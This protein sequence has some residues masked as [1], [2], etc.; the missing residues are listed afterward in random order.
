MAVS[1]ELLVKIS[2]DTKDATAGIAE[3]NQSLKGMSISLKEAAAGGD[4]SLLSL[5]DS[6][7]K[8]RAANEKIV[9]SL[10]RRGKTQVDIARENKTATDQNIASIS[11]MLSQ[12]GK[13]TDAL[14]A[15]LSKTK[16]LAAAQQAATIQDAQ[17]DALDKLVKQNEAVNH[18]LEVQKADAL[19]LAAINAAKANKELDALRESLK[20]QGL[21]NVQI[22]KQ[23]TLARQNIDAQKGIDIVAAE[24]KKAAEAAKT[25]NAALNEQSKA[26]VGAGFSFIALNQALELAQKLW[27]G[28]SGPVEKAVEAFAAGEKADM[29]LSNS[30]KAMGQSSQGAFDDLKNLSKEMQRNSSISDETV[31]SMASVAKSMGLSNEQT[32]KVIKSSADMAAVMGTDVNTAFN[33]LIGQY[34]GVTGRGAKYVT[35]LKDLN[36]A[37]LKAGA[38]IELVAKQFAGFAEAEGKTLGG[39]ITQ[40]KNAF[41][42]LLETIGETISGFFDLPGSIQAAKEVILDTTKS[43]KVFA[44]RLT[45][46]KDGLSG[47]SFSEIIAGVSGIGTA[48]AVALVAL[49]VP[50]IVAALT[51]IGTALTTI[52]GPAVL[53]AGQFVLITGAIL[54]VVIAIETVVKN[55]ERL[56]QL[57]ETI[58]VAFE[59][60]F[61]RLIRGFAGVG[62]AGLSAIEMILEP[63][64][65]FSD[66]A[67]SA[68]GSVRSGMLSLGNVAED[69]GKSVDELD[70]KLVEASKGLEMGPTLGLIVQ[71]VN[72][73]KGAMGDVNV[74]TEA[75]KKGFD[76]ISKINAEIAKPTK[77]QLQ[78]LQQIRS[79]N[80]GLATEVDGMGA[81]EIERLKMQFSIMDAQ[82]AV[83]KNQLEVEGK[84]AG[85]GGQKIIAALNKQFDLQKELTQKRIVDIEFKQ[86]GGFGEAVGRGAVDFA[87]MFNVG[88][89]YLSGVFDMALP[90]ISAA[91]RDGFAV[92]AAKAAGVL[93]SVFSGFADVVMKMFDPKFIQGMADALSG[94]VEKFP[95]LLEKAF[96]ALSD[97]FGKI[98]DKLPEV[99]NKLFDALG[100]IFDKLIAQMP[101]L[102]DA[103]AAALVTF[104]ERL[105]E[106][107]AKLFDALPGIIDKLLEKLP[108][109]IEAFL[110]A[111]PQIIVS[112]IK[113]IPGII[114][115][116]L[117]R[118]PEIIV[119]VVSGLI[120]A[121]GEITAA[122]IDFII[123]GGL[124][125]IVVALI[126]AVPRIAIALVV[127]I[128]NGLKRAM[129]AIFGGIKTPAF[130]G[131]MEELP[132]KLAKGLAELGKG[133]AKE[134][135]K[136]FKVLDLE[137]EAA[138]VSRLK[139]AT[140][141]TDVIDIAADIVNDRIGGMW[142]KFINGLLEV[143]RFVYNTFLKPWVELLQSAWKVVIQ[144]LTAWGQVLKGVWDA[145][146]GLLNVWVGLLK[147]AWNVV[148]VAMTAWLNVLRAAWDGIISV[149][150]TAWGAMAGVMTAA[151]DG[152]VAIFS[153]LWEGIKTIWN[154]LMDLFQGKIS[155]FEALGKIWGAMFDTAKVVLES[156]A[157]V[158]K[159]IFDGLKD[160]FDAAV[161]AFK[162][163]FS[164]FTDGAS[165]IGTAIWDGL[166]KG[167]DGAASIFTK[168]GS[169]V[170]E[171]LKSGLSGVGN[172]LKEA[173]NVINPANLLGKIFKLDNKEPGTV[174]KILGI[175]IPFVSFAQGGLVPG[176]AALPGDSLVN[177]RV[178]A[179]VSPGEAVIPRSVTTNPS[180][181]PY[182]QALLSGDAE[183]KLPPF[184]GISVSTSGV[185]VDTSGGS[186]NVSIT[187]PSM[188]TLGQISPE[189]DKVWHELEKLDPS[190]LWDLAKE[191][192]WKGIKAMFES[193]A[194][195]LHDGGMVQAYA[196]GGEVPAVLQP[197]EFVMQRNAVNQFGAGLLG[198]M[199]NGGAMPSGPTTTNIDVSVSI[200]ASSQSLDETYIRTK[201]IPTIKEEFRRASSKGDYLISNR[202]VREA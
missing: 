65:K 58:E 150:S 69:A 39:A 200:N 12:Q 8:F 176:T 26:A 130:A 53:V 56:P 194:Q 190:K 52:V 151:W 170:W 119:A 191:Q 32:K 137:N 99:I 159:K 195:R 193:S 66:T 187:P 77:E 109:I 87:N 7:E 74:E 123:N 181:A 196:G 107:F 59:N 188:P 49:N 143:W 108:A 136:V 164:A 88:S 21:M 165:K 48:L 84:L 174:E 184:Y 16:E 106:L 101:A 134:A 55:M 128:V 198:R 140:K 31:L 6:A 199:N 162:N 18:S 68:L 100:R 160:I 23:I 50:A 197:G 2:V 78:L 19:Q 141:V 115:A 175:N 40:S 153:S 96:M 81:T 180:L 89:S 57:G 155:I 43:V 112:L 38:G 127:G 67:A 35:G 148:A 104:I 61:E 25:A 113:A 161:A 146:L 64:A 166:K 182:V 62:I 33:E 13:M 22:E 73:I 139:D 183:K 60:M 135:S 145:V 46:L 54:G 11:D 76:D 27:R 20:S 63:L 116:I 120:G 14:A 179:L 90:K 4:Q 185:S 98:I 70:A 47:I 3:I 83:R 30:L 186:P 91:T 28:L 97:A 93:G 117:E 144:L 41:D 94:L 129:G 105:P 10:A 79:E 201:L 154:T 126:K 192:A 80:L 177:D 157:N 138:S 131:K 133:V 171:S 152:I 51:T 45:I 102:I 71:G 34:S 172:L 24:Q 75:V 125:K 158:F 167:L 103:L 122:L 178:I 36:E 29:L 110:V 132:K 15:Q 95:E 142:Q 149:L 42:D 5:V 156:V 17:L 121:M 147:S 111:I 114:V 72:A 44:E 189:A 163:T 124:E 202:G 169:T 86:V 118:L 168:L 82:L 85:E 173:I 1:D 9:A 92:G 37:Q